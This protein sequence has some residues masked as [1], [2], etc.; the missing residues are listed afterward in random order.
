VRLVA[1][2]DEAAAPEL[3]E[4]GS[5]GSEQN[6]WKSST[7]LRTRFGQSLTGSAIAAPH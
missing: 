5:G 6:A 3:A 1:A 7:S 4:G 2:L